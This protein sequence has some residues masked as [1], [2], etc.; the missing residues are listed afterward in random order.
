MAKAKSSISEKAKFII[1]T[2]GW[3][4]KAWQGYFYPN[5]L[6][7]KEWLNYYQENFKV[8]EINSTF[9][10]FFKD[11]ILIGWRKK[12]KGDFKYI[13]KVNRIITHVKYLKNCKELIKQFCQSARLL[14]NKLALILLQLPPRMPYDLERLAEALDCFDDPKRVVVEFRNEKW[15]TEEVRVLLKKKGSIFCAADSP[16]TP[17]T[18]WVTAKTAYIRLHGRKKWFDYKYSRAEL[19]EIAS[20][21]RNLEKQG[22]KKIFILFNN[23]WY[24]YA[25]E[26]AKLLQQILDS[27]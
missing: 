2:S 12:A 13:I 7:Q 22:A 17:L 8:V 25:V 1:G 20:F 4:Y 11:D 27:A 5:D 15:L 6:P 18:A 16:T 14:E 3:I 19:K 23:D 9:Y 24:A 26:N 21:A 10:R